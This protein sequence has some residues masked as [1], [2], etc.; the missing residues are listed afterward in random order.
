M[1]TETMANRGKLFTM[2]WS[3]EE[4]AQAEAVARNYG[5]SVA[6]LVRMLIDREAKPMGKEADT[7]SDPFKTRDVGL[8]ADLLR[9]LRTIHEEVYRAPVMMGDQLVAQPVAMDTIVREVTPDWLSGNAS[10]PA[11]VNALRRAGHIMK[12]RGGYAITAKGLDAIRRNKGS[13]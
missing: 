7:T 13:K 11:L 1:Q 8:R 12:Q 6:G 10:L 9:V 5:L 3:D 2:R 4:A